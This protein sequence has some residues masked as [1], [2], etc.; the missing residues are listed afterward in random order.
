MTTT[1]VRGKNTCNYCNPSEDESIG[2]PLALREGMK[3]LFALLCVAASLAITPT[4]AQTASQDMKAAGSD[5]KDAAKDTGKAT[6]K[7]AKKAK[8]KTK[9]EVHKASSKVSNSTAGH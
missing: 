9:H 1:P 3:T 2:E 5:V 4:F 6:K 8:H 7:A